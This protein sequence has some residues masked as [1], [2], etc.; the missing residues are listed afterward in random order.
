MNI[1]LLLWFGILANCEMIQRGYERYDEQAACFKIDDVNG[2]FIEV[3]LDTDGSEPVKAPI[4]IVRD[5]EDS[6]GNSFINEHMFFSKDW[7]DILDVDKFKIEPDMEQTK[8]VNTYITS[9]KSDEHA[10]V[11][12][13]PDTPGKYCVYV[14]VPETVEKFKAPL[15]VRYAHGYLEPRLYQR[16][17]STKKLFKYMS[18]LWGVF[19][20]DYCLFVRRF[21]LKSISVVTLSVLASHAPFF[22]SLVVKLV[23]GMRANSQPD[24]RS[25]DE[26]RDFFSEYK[27]KGLYSFMIEYMF[28]AF[29]LGYGTV[30]YHKYTKVYR[31]F[32]PSKLKWGTY[33]LALRLV[34]YCFE[35]F[36]GCGSEDIKWYTLYEDSVKRAIHEGGHFLENMSLFLSL[37]YAVKTFKAFSKFTPPPATLK[38]YGT[39]NYKIKRVFILTTTLLKVFPYVEKILYSHLMRQIYGYSTEPVEWDLTLEKIQDLESKFDIANYS[40]YLVFFYFFWMRPNQ[41]LVPEEVLS[42]S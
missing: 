25:Y 6:E 7:D 38:N 36:F 42:K 11:R 23:V 24:N 22:L 33:I 41:G 1:N 12:L 9:D 2:A 34:C 28:L 15:K 4:L 32:T 20:L 21:E 26:R 40:V 17:A 29:C 5:I 3:S 19:L 10:L 14:A 13:E 39:G 27:G 37:R 18:I 16:Y 30:Y 35:S 8:H 31:K